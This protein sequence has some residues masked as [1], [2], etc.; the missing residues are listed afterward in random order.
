MIMNAQ[1]EEISKLDSFELSS[2]KDKKVDDMVNE[3]LN[4]VLLRELKEKLFPQRALTK[5]A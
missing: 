4:N 2:D 1:N 3:I 5:V